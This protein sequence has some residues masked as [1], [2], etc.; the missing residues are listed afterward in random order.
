MFVLSTV[1]GRVPYLHHSTGSALVQRVVESSCQIEHS[2]AFMQGIK[3]KVERISSPECTRKR[4][5]QG[6]MYSVPW[7]HTLLQRRFCRRP[8][9]SLPALF[10][11]PKLNSHLDCFSAGT[12]KAAG[13]EEPSDLS[14]Q[15]V[16]SLSLSLYLCLCLSVSLSLSLQTWVWLRPRYRAT[17]SSTAVTKL[18]GCFD[19]GASEDTHSHTSEMFY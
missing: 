2:T 1:W 19:F 14:P 8:Y 7:S 9:L 12:L 18:M 5:N 13:R 17:T 16:F 6:S 11:N 4:L 3:T 10:W 15:R